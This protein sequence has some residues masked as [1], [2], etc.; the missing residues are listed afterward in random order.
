MKKSKKQIKKDCKEFFENLI[1][2]TDTYFLSD[3]VEDI[4]DYVGK[5]EANFLIK[6]RNQLKKLCEENKIDFHKISCEVASQF[7]QMQEI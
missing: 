2:R 5:K 1:K 6:E 7:M 3:Y 4:V